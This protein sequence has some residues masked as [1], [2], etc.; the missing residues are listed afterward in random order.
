M[1]QPCTICTHAQRAAI[2]RAL[3]SGAPNRRV[4]E[5]YGVTEQAIRRH[6]DRH[7]P[8]ALTQAQAAEQATRA[9]ALLEQVE[10]LRNKAVAI[11][12]RAEKSGELRTALHAIRE[13]RE[14]IELLLEVEGRLQRGNV[15]NVL[16]APQWIELRAVIL[17]ALAPYPEARAALAS[18]LQQVQDDGYPGA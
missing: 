16:V 6:R 15:V 9:G 3:V 18:A 8:E 1:P 14:C 4:A 10:G 5:E 11:L 12:L 17:G 13:A 2:D 7:V